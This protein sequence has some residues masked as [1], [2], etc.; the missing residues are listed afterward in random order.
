MIDDAI[1]TL[2]LFLCGVFLVMFI[3]RVCNRQPALKHAF[4][5]L[6]FCLTL[7]SLATCF[8]IDY[9]IRQ[10]VEYDGTAHD[11]EAHYI[12]N[13]IKNFN[14]HSSSWMVIGN[15]GYRLFLGVFYALTNAGPVAIYGIN[16]AFGYLGMLL[17]LESSCRYFHAKRCPAILVLTAMALPSMMLWSPKNLKEGSIIFCIGLI[18]RW[19]AHPTESKKAFGDHLSFAFG[20]VLLFYF[21]PHIAAA[22]VGGMAIGAAQP[23]KS[24]P[25]AFFASIA[26][27]SIGI[28]A[29]Y[30]VEIAKPGFNQE[31]ADQGLTETMNSR[32]ETRMH[33]GNTAIYRQTNPIPVGTGLMIILLSPPP[34]LWASPPWLI[35]GLESL[36]LTSASLASW[37][38]T[39]VQ[40]LQLV[41]DS[42]VIGSL[43]TIIFL[44]FFLTYS[45]NVGLA[46]RQKMQVTPAIL[47]LLAAPVF[48]AQHLR[49]R[50]TKRLSD[51]EIFPES[52][53]AK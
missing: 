23:T 53:T 47:L 33:M 15:N 42:I 16:A 28:S 14:L 6:L 48:Q 26:F 52:S 3:Q 17:V 20:S 13:Q 29:F 34:Y 2:I 1:S 41:R 4:P 19:F 10:G 51:S 43:Y 39:K 24:L 37:M 40:R 21:R 45:Y 50:A 44:A 32:Y 30:A 25:K 12:A 49:S 38:L 36:F 31:V 35:L 11:R 22:W 9:H 46:V 5:I 7:W 18:V 27:L 8:S